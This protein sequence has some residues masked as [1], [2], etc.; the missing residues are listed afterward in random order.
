MKSLYIIIVLVL[1]IGGFFYWY[2]ASKADIGSLNIYQGNADILRKEKNIAGRTGSTIKLKDTIRVAKDSR[3]SIVLKDGSV[4]RLEAGSE[5]GVS[6]L[7]YN[8]TKIKKALFDLRLGRLWS[9]VEPLEAGGSYNVQT[10]TVV[11]TIRG[12]IFNVDYMQIKS[13]IYVDDHEVGT[14]LKLLPELF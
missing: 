13:V 3:V 11:A 12:T 9:H 4:I 10:P 1:V 8:G 14:F 7:E 6:E 2:Q 5:V